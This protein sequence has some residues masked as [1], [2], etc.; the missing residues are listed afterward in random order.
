MVGLAAERG[1]DAASRIVFSQLEVLLGSNSELMVKASTALAELGGEDHQHAASL[2]YN[3]VRA[4][5]G[6]A[7]RDASGLRARL[8]SVAGMPTGD[9][10][11]A[12]ETESSL[13]GPAASTAITVE[14][15]S[16]YFTWFAVFSYADAGAGMPAHVTRS[17]LRSCK[18]ASPQ[19][20]APPPPEPQPVPQPL[21]PALPAQA[22]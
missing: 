14:P 11:Y 17:T 6:L 19:S 10:P 7:Y 15:Q 13:A 18:P 21:Q 3:E 20:S 9:A 12:L 22:P 8:I 5:W 1:C 2:A 4:N 16:D